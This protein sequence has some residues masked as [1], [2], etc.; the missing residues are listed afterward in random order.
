[1]SLRKFLK[2]CQAIGL[3]YS[4]DKIVIP[5][6]RDVPWIAD[7]LFHKRPHHSRGISLAQTCGPEQAP[8]I[9]SC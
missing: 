8:T 5:L 3:A 1:M 6:P 4:D 7:G 2:E 9:R